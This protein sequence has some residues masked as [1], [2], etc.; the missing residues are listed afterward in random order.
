MLSVGRPA[1]GNENSLI[2][3]FKLSPDGKFAVRVPVR[4]GRASVNS[5]Q[6]LEGLA[7]GDVVILV[8][9]EPV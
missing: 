2:T 3:L 5:I 7:E 1:T 9:Y 4:V 6:V 8:G